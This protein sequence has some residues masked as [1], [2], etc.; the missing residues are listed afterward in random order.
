MEVEV[1]FWWFSDTLSSLFFPFS[2][3]VLGLGF[4]GFSRLPY[5]FDKSQEGAERAESSS[6]SCLYP[7]FELL[8]EHRGT[9]E[10]GSGNYSRAAELSYP[11]I[12]CLRLSLLRVLFLII[13]HN[14]RRISRRLNGKQPSLCVIK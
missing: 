12:I 1:D 2:S 9:S 11:F 10:L 6:G 8:C 14:S 5:I 13:D 4:L 7:R 3:L